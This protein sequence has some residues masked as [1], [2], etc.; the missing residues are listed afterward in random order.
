MCV[1]DQRQL[2]S[3]HSSSIFDQTEN[4]EMAAGAPASRQMPPQIVVPLGKLIRTL[5][6]VNL[7]STALVLRPQFVIK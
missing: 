5:G 4:T 1:P 6:Q 2:S 3:R 7:D